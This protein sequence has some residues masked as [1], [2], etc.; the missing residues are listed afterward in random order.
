MFVGRFDEFV[1]FGETPE[2]IF[3]SI[4]RSMESQDFLESDFPQDCADIEFFQCTRV[5][6][7][8]RGWEFVVP[9][10]DNPHDYD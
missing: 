1:G 2:E 9:E 10:Q 5:G 3:E 7:I 8:R 6:I 4:C